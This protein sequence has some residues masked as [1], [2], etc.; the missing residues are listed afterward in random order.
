MEPYYNTNVPPHADFFLRFF[1]C[2]FL[3][4]STQLFE[5]VS[6][7][8]SEN[9][10]L[11]ECVFLRG[12]EESRR[13]IGEEQIPQWIKAQKSLRDFC[14]TTKLFSAQRYRPEHW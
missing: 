7:I 6:R 2:T 12:V 13:G 8:A 14:V 10:T 3:R 5:I 4:A 9:G 1:F 11:R